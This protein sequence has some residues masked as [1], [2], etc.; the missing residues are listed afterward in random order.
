MYKGYLC[1][2][3]HG[4][5]VHRPAIAATA[6]KHRAAAS[7][8]ALPSLA[9]GVPGTYLNSV[10]QARWAEVGLALLAAGV[11][12]AGVGLPSE[13][14]R[15]MLENWFA[16]RTTS[17]RYHK[18]TVTI[19]LVAERVGLHQ[20]EEGRKDFFL[21]FDTTETTT[22]LLT[23]RLEHLEA[24][25]P[26]LGSAAMLAIEAAAGRCFTLMTPLFARHLASRCLWWGASDQE[27][28]EAEMECAEADA[29]DMDGFI[30]PAVYDA[31][32]PSWMIN[33]FAGK[34]P[35][36]DQALRGLLSNGDE[37]VG[38]IAQCVRTINRLCRSNASLPGLGATELE[39]VCFPVF[40][41]TANT[42]P[43]GWVY[44]EHINFANESADCFTES[45]GVQ[46][47][48]INPKELRSELKA[49]S[50]GFEL[51]AELDRLLTL[52]GEPAPNFWEMS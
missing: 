37:H 39:T 12:P 15:Q 45:I 52:V 1:L 43:I 30:T 50:K 13:V 11:S 35:L 18:L 47:F 29:D 48:S 5:S 38:E 20:V 3:G 2:G 31:A 23:D 6:N 27:E 36:S 9:P 8:V 14:V 10:E 32:F 33:L 28:F 19:S 26:G 25:V 44:D 16:E 51:L 34:R 24:V 42:D 49:L 4:S 40:V 7:L 17:L 22:C 46:N 41:R 21:H